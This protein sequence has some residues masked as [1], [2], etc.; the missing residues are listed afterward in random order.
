MRWIE[1]A[2]FLSLALGSILYFMLQEL[3]EK[4]IALQG[5][6]W[7]ILALIMLSIAFCCHLYMRS[8]DQKL[9]NKA[10]KDQHRDS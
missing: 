5:G 10:E 2:L 9:K 4:G 3:N 7:V 1:K 6:I 8:E